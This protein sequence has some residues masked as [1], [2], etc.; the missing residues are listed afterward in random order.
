MK[1]FRFFLVAC[2]T[3]GLLSA[4]PAPE[5]AERAD[6]TPPSLTW[7]TP[8]NAEVSVQY[9][10]LTADLSDPSGLCRVEISFDRGRSWE[11][12]WNAANF[13]PLDSTTPYTE[14]TWTFGGPLPTS[15]TQV[16][17]AR[18]VDCAGNVGAGEIL[19]IRGK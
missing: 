14:T 4:A 9:P 16:F 1:T 18:A 7:Q 15:G 12:N 17:I 19:V 13:P 6:Q 11:E 3:L 5:A 2:L 10:N 8:F